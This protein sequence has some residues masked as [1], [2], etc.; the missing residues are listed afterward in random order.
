MPWAARALA[1][2]PLVLLLDEPLSN[3]D[4]Y[5]VLRFLELLRTAAE[6]QGQAVLVSLHDLALLPRF[7]RA[8]LVAG[9]KLQ[10]DEAPA[11]LKASERFEDIFQ[12]REG[13]DGGWTIRTQAGPRPSP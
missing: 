13:A 11:D 1:P 9:G 10:M 12:V 2:R 6:A 7:D 5:W 8:L 4:P 3:L